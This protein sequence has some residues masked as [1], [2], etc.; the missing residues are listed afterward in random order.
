MLEDL[1]AFGQEPRT[2]NTNI[3]AM[4]ISTADICNSD[5][6]M[7]ST[8]GTMADLNKRISYALGL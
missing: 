4:N 1:S 8:N 6:V 2:G 5:F 3:L 7:R